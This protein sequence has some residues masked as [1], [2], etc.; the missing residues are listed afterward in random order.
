VKDGAGVVESIGEVGDGC[1]VGIHNGSVSN[2]TELNTKYNRDFKV[3]SIH[4]FANIAQGFPTREISGYGA[5]AWYDEGEL[6]LGKFNGGD[7]HVVELASGE[8]VFCSLLQTILD[9]ADM[10]GAEAKD[11]YDIFGDRQ[12]KIQQSPEDKQKDELVEVG[13]MGFGGRVTYGG[14]QPNGN[15]TM[16]V[17][18]SRRYDVDTDHEPW[19]GSQYQSYANA[20]E[21]GMCRDC[22]V[23]VLPDKKN[24]LVCKKCYEAKELKYIEEVLNGEREFWFGD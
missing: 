3:D 9:A 17:I 21:K 15:P 10:V 20:R 22:R 7:L 8:V 19:E 4:L 24:T 1:V 5:L 12:Y 11:E 18:M 16:P 23:V 2:Y 13:D 14:Y 6:N